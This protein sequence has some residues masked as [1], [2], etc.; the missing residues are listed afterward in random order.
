MVMRTGC[1]TATDRPMPLRSPRDTHLPSRTP[2]VRLVPTSTRAFPG[3]PAMHGTEATSRDE[4][5]KKA[6]ERCTVHD[7]P[8]RSR[9]HRPVDAWL[10]CGR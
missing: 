7:G 9:A 2:S 6:F 3:A 8:A 10:P 1:A 5:G 4:Q